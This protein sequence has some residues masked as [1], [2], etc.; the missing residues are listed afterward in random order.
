MELHRRKDELTTTK[1]ISNNTFLGH[2]TASRV[3]SLWLCLSVRLP[4]W[5]SVS[6]SRRKQRPT[7][8]R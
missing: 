3:C 2:D 8:K 5:I 1:H 4:A 7:R 6:L